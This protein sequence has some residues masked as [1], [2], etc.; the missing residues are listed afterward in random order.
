M[1]ILSILLI[2]LGVSTIS[3]ATQIKLVD[4]NASPRTRSLFEYLIN[5]S[6]KGVLFGH[7]NTFYQGL[8]IDP[9]KKGQSDVLNSVGDFP[10]LFGFDFLLFDQQSPKKMKEYIEEA[11]NLGGIIS[12][13]DHM[14]NFTTGGG[15][16][17]TTKTVRNILPG[18]KDF[19]TYRNY[20]T[21]IADFANSLKSEN[22]NDIPIIYRPFHE[23]HGSWFWWGAAFCSKAEYIALWR[24]TVDYLKSKG[25][26]NFLY[27]YSPSGSFGGS[28][29]EYLKRYPG[30]D[31]VDI[32]GFDSYD[33]NPTGNWDKIMI[34][35]CQML[36]K[37]AEKKNK[38]PVIAETGISGG[39][40]L[41]D[42]SNKEW[43]SKRMMDIIMH[44][45]LTRKIVY[46]LVWRNGNDTHFW[47]PFK[48]HPK[49]G[50]HEMLVD[51]QN[52]YKN[53]YSVFLKELKGVYN[54][55]N[56]RTL[57]NK[58][59]VYLMNPLNRDTISEKQK[60][61]VRTD[62]DPENIKSVIFYD[63]NN[64]VNLI[65]NGVFYTG[66]WNVTVKE[67]PVIKNLRIELT[68][69]NGKILTENI[70]VR[71]I[72]KVKSQENQIDNFEGYF[73][74]EDL[75]DKYTRNSSGNSVNLSLLK[76]KDT[77]AL[78]YNYTLGY[79]NYAGVNRAVDE[80]N[81]WSKY[82]GIQFNL[83]HSDQPVEL[84]IQIKAGGIPWEAY[85]D[86][87]KNKDNPIKLEFAQ[88][89]LPP[90]KQGNYKIDLNKVTE[91]S[92]YVGVKEKLTKD[93]NGTLVFTDIKLYRKR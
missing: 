29:K 44:D 45:E 78:K 15:Y 5:E 2:L 76:E 25:V 17:D 31:Y 52:F 83:Q 58:N 34:K 46:F 18:G 49:Y 91:F 60:I 73:D 47:V 68:E 84:T 37:L 77:T 38:I 24:Y 12:V 16:G 55:K 81:N 30:D 90:W 67:K 10:A 42:N 88:F 9:N 92:I 33:S 87:G 82:H 21:K 70:K 61:I 57:P 50:D 35:D 54:Y 8:T 6:G 86:L 40:K 3:F 56:I 74:K 79:P 22:G 64:K 48:N 41:K 71:V 14:K 65:R 80:N 85:V 51:F 36:V 28:E 53:P 26:N 63:K 13:S 32:L 19:D 11:Y 39:I 4:P 23:N 75:N 20:L 93:I 59:Y 72:N 27:A 43:Y 66:E 62:I 69:K 1:K 7:E 89:K